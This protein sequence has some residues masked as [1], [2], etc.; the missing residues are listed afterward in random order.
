MILQGYG[1]KLQKI[2]NKFKSIRKKIWEKIKR[3]LKKKRKFSWG[4]FTRN[5]KVT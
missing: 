3:N 5:L 2:K 4:K 1:E